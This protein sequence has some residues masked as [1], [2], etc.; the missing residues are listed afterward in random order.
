VRLGQKAF[1]ANRRAAAILAT[2]AIDH[3]D[4]LDGTAPAPEVKRA[5]AIASPYDAPH[6]K[7]IGIAVRI[8]DRESH[9]L[10]VATPCRQPYG[11]V[12]ALASADADRIAIPSIEGHL[13]AAKLNPPAVAIVS[14]AA[15]RH[16][17]GHDRSGAYERG[18]G[19][20]TES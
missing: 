13:L 20:A 3:V 10:D 12:T 11:P 9:D 19:R 1:R 18:Q 6:V 16:G 8:H 14:I 17:I 15:L 2:L 7:L 4:T 5:G